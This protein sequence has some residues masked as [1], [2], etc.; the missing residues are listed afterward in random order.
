VLGIYAE[1]D[2]RINADRDA[3]EAALKAANLP[4][5]LVTYPA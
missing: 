1:Q 5:E 3:A 4:H 2:T